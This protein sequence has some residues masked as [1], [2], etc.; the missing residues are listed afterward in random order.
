MDENDYYYVLDEFGWAV[1][2]TYIKY[3]YG[4]VK[5]Y[6]TSFFTCNLSD[7]TACMTLNEFAE[8]AVD[9]KGILWRDK[10][11]EE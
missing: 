2:N 3:G 1:L 5:M 7:E 4:K 9:F 8:K 6:A 11:N 10:D